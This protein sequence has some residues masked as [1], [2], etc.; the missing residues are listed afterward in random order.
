MH[1]PSRAALD[2]CTNGAYQGLLYLLVLPFLGASARCPCLR[3]PARAARVHP[4]YLVI[5]SSNRRLMIH[6]HTTPP[7]YPYLSGSYS[8]IS[9]YWTCSLFWVWHEY[10]SD[11]GVGTTKI[12]N[13]DQMTF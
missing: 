2:G 6:V 4:T 3:V 10:K 5:I 9:G 8:S 11:I 12:I 1:D 7:D 13:N